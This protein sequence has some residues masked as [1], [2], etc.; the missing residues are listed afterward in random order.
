LKK[1]VTKREAERAEKAD[2]VDQEDL[3]EIKGR[4]PLRLP[5][6]F[7]RPGL[8]GKR[9]AGDLEIHVNGIRYQSH[10]K[11]DQRINVAFSNIKHFFFQPCDGEMLVLIHVQLKDAIMVGKRK[12]FY[13][14]F[15]REVSDASFDETGNRRR[16][17]NYG[18]EDELAQEQEERRH[19]QMLNK[20]FQQFSDRVSELVTRLI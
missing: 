6:V 4:R 20:E 9:Y 18:D 10:V 5:D 8:E 13:V 3:I 2:L 7:A 11:S 1:D 17:T 15:Y 12:T 16:R 14:Q 19:R